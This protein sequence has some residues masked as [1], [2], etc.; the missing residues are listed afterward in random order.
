VLARKS[1]HLH[2]LDREI[3]IWSSVNRDAW[4]QHSELYTPVLKDAKV[5]LDELA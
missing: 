5:L 2:L 4:K 1:K 3:V